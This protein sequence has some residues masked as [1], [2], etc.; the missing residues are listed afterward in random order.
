MLIKMLRD[1]ARGILH[2]HSEH[3]IHRDISARNMLVAKVRFIV[4]C[5]CVCAF[6]DQ[7]CMLRSHRTPRCE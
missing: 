3:V 6:P 1:A 7:A 2:L 5:A 4:A